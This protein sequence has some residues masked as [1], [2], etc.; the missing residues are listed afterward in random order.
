VL[1]L[2]RRGDTALIGLEGL[3]RHLDADGVHGILPM[4]EFERR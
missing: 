1:G 3:V 4:S 2:E